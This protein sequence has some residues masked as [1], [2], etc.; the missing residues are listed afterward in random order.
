VL[1]VL[2]RALRLFSA[3]GARFLGAAVAFYAM[4]SAAPLFVVLLHAVGALLGRPRA[5]SALWSALGTWLA[6]DGLETVRVLTERVEAR[7]ASGSVVGIVVLV[8]AS[9]RLFR[10]LRRALNHLYGIDLE[11]VERA[12]PRALRY[13]LRYGQAIAFT[14]LAAVL[15]VLLLACKT[16]VALAEAPPALLFTLDAVASTA[17]TFLLFA[18]LFRFLPERP[19]SWR[20]AAVSALASTV[21]FAAGSE[22]V[23]LY[24][25]HKH[26]G[27]LYEG[28]T[29]TVVLVV[30]I[31]Y[32]AQVFFLGASVGA[33]LAETDA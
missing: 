7:A 26:L 10:A 11:A 9:T 22:V 17:V 6:P 13:G 21:L 14:L 5:E 30:W 8:Y 27:E 16:L 29:A 1:D 23:T 33:T 15:V 25:R 12:K 18:A 20:D 31:Y 32:S 4:L 2:R 19:V 3:R 24:V 28:A